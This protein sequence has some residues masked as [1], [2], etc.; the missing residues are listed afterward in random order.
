MIRI[1]Y[2]MTFSIIEGFVAE[3][4]AKQ[5]DPTAPGSAK[6]KRDLKR[7][8]RPNH[9]SLMHTLVKF[10]ANQINEEQQAMGKLEFLPKLF[11]SNGALAKKIGCSNRTIQN[12]MDR[13]MEAGFVVSKRFRGSKHPYALELNLRAIFLVKDGNPAILSYDHSLVAS[14]SDSPGISPGKVMGS[15]ED[16]GKDRKRP[17][18]PSGAVNNVVGIGSVIQEISHTIPGSQ[19][20]NRDL[21]ERE[22][23]TLRHKEAGYIQKEP[24]IRSGENVNNTFSDISDISAG[25]TT[26]QENL[27]HDHQENSVKNSTES[28]P[29]NVSDVAR[30][31]P[32]VAVAPPSMEDLPEPNK[33]YALQLWP[34]IMAHLYYKLP[35][36][37]P[38]Q[39]EALDRFLHDEFQGLSPQQ[40]A[41]RKNELQIRIHMVWKWLRRDPNRFIPI[42]SKYFDRDNEFGFIRTKLWYEQEKQKKKAVGEAAAWSD[43][44]RD[45][46]RLFNN[47]VSEAIRKGDFRTYWNNRRRIEKRDPELLNAFDL[48]VTKKQRVA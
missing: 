31:T 17:Y 41:K 15:T 46:W 35:Y 13:L 4:N 14:D 36:L 16:P 38:S 40:A 2:S 5:N 9:V 45:R 44:I 34:L 48:M 7:Q 10:Y 22:R 11:T 26:G 8:L 3:W 30:T 21:P 29:L 43:E 24:I 1:N 42:P 27:G 39:R 47:C 32:P 12:L 25:N 23:K 6:V 33:E 20:E 18:S 28:D 19:N 37:A